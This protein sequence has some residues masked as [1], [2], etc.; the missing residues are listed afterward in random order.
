MTLYNL[1]PLHDLQIITVSGTKTMYRSTGIDPCFDIELT[2]F[3]KKGLYRIHISIESCKGRIR[4]PKIYFDIGKGY[5]EEQTILL[6][7]I[8]ENTIQS[9]LYFPEEILHIRFDPTI[10]KDAE[11]NLEYLKLEPAS[12]NKAIPKK[13]TTV[14]SGLA[15]VVNIE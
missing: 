6:P 8:I 1:I 11:F 10:L 15:G 3:L 13:D 9:L 12:T 5:N 2:E 14:L 7:P 4:A